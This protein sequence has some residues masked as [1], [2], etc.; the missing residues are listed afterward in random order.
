MEKGGRRK[1]GKERIEEG[2]EKGGG[3]ETKGRW[4]GR[5]EGSGRRDGKKGVGIERRRRG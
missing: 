2:A 3:A 1:A 5:S 4:R